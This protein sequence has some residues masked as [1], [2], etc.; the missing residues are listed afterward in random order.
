MKISIIVPVYN[1]EDYVLEC[2]ESIGTQSFNGEIECLIIDDRGSDK[3]MEIVEQYIST[4]T[5]NVEFKIIPHDVNHGLGA[6]RNTGID[7]STGDYLLFVDSD[8]KLLAGSVERLARGA[9]MGDYPLIISPYVMSNEEINTAPE[10]FTFSI[11]DSPFINHVKHMTEEAM[12]RAFIVC[13]WGKLIKSSFVRDHKLRFPVGILYEDILWSFK[14]FSQCSKSISISAPSIYYRIRPNS[15]MTGNS[16]KKWIEG[17]IQNVELLTQYCTDD[18]H[19]DYWTWD[20]IDHLNRLILDTIENTDEALD[21]HKLLDQLTRANNK[22]FRQY[23]KHGSATISQVIKRCYFLLPSTFSYIIWR[24]IRST[25]P[26]L[27]A[28]NTR[29]R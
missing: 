23:I 4:Y 12:D 2:L 21:K 13:A 26:K 7:L 18:E 25:G 5:G 16:R 9:S 19:F 6:A 14:L 20:Y 8:D 27:S 24:A 15:I 28:I 22:Y 11:S 3:S 17:H 10:E 29:T 1:V